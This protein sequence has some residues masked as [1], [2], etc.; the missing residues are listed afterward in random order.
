MKKTLLTLA[1]LTLTLV[2]NAA[3][4]DTIDQ[5]LVE[6]DLVADFGMVADDAASDQSAKLQ[7]AIDEISAKGGGRI[8]LPAGTYSFNSIYMNSNV[9]LVI[10]KGVII[11]PF[12]HESQKGN[13]VFHFT[14]KSESRKGEEGFIENVSIRCSEEG[15]YFTIDYSHIPLNI[16][17]KRQEK[18]SARAFKCVQVRNFMIEGMYVIDNWT[19]HC[20]GIFVPSKIEGCDEWEVYKPTAGLIR[21]FKSINSSPGY[22]LAQLHAGYDLRFENLST[23][24]GGITF[25]L[26]TGAGGHYG[27]VDQI[28]ADTI[29]CEN[30]VT[31]M[32]MGPH[33]AKNGMVT[34]RNITAL[35]CGTAVQMGPGF[36]DGRENSGVPGRFADGCLIENVHA[37][38]GENAPIATKTI[39]HL[40]EWQLE[41]LWFDEKT[42]LIRGPSQWIA[43]DKTGDSWSPT[44][45]D[46][47]SEGF[48]PEISPVLE[49]EKQPR[50]DYK[51]ILKNY[52]IWKELP[53]YLK[54]GSKKPKKE[55]KH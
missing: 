25:R 48:S 38:Y 19:T 55:R 50:S 14:N 17:H 24:N 30:G 26:E 3:Y 9:H 36:D 6:K 45:R 11:K 53:E 18:H 8:Y 20:A 1:T 32:A 37:V 29:Y 39:S 21:N 46:V 42:Q 13:G 22:G 54:V 52:S 51:A 5:V 16:K 4:I 44:I 23:T 34:A 10:D 49:R 35:S 47:T 2:G 41:R 40:A 15:E 12:L 43:H 31:A 33:T 27:G 7:D 28:S